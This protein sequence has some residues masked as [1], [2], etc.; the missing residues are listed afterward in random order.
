M[1]LSV[2]TPTHDPGY[3]AAAY[4][5][6]KPQPFDEWLILL[7]GRATI[8]DVPVEI[9]T[10]PRVRIVS[11]QTIG[12]VGALKKEACTLAS[13]CIL[14][15]LDHDDVPRPGAIEKA[16]Q[17]FEDP[18]VVF[19][20]SNCAYFMPIQY[21]FPGKDP[22]NGWVEREYIWGDRTLRETVAPEPHPCNVSTIHYA[23]DHFRAF[24]KDAYLRCGGHDPALHVLDDQNLM[25]KL[26]LEG[27][28]KH[29]DECLYLYRVDLA[30]TWIK[31]QAY[32][33][34]HVLDD[35]KMYFPQMAEAWARRQGLPVFDL[36]EESF[37]DLTNYEPST[38]GVV[39]AYGGLLCGQD[40]HHTLAAVH[41]ALVPGGTLLSATP[42]AVMAQA[43]LFYY[44]DRA[45]GNQI[46]NKTIR[47]FPALIGRCSVEQDG[48]DVASVGAFLVALKQD[49]EGNELCRIHGR[50]EI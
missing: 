16:K 29:I 35:R 32:I 5:E 41:R 1:R 21:W 28:F 50:L 40:L 23:P 30:N 13:G 45:Y 24:R 39:R 6:L 27:E 14:F 25:C 11:T 46:G 7:N 22:Q 44:T 31:K 33:D 10:D 38:L 3:L 8:N 19:A 4:K 15:E 18:N 43:E 20:Y 49:A 48:Q 12:S 37:K 34:E 9:I 42:A 36:T 17:A 26:Y 47:F 2:F